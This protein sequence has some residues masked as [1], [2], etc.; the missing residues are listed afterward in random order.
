MAAGGKR[1]LGPLVASAIAEAAA[2]AALAA[3]FA[4]EAGFDVE[5]GR[6]VE[7]HRILTA[8]ADVAHRCPDAER[9]REPHEK[10][11]PAS[12]GHGNT[13]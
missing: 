6:R 5:K 8:A 12:L 4:V 3:P 10:T 7:R 2:K 11:V 13:S 1:R 9:Y